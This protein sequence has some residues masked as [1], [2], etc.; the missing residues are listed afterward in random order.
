MALRS[1][2]VVCVLAACIVG[3]GCG[4]GGVGSPPGSPVAGG[5]PTAGETV[6]LGTLQVGVASAAGFKTLTLRSPDNSYIAFTVLYGSRILRLQEMGYERI[7]FASDRDGDYEI[8]TMNAD[9]SDRVKLTRNSAN[10]NDPAWSPDG[11][12][13]AFASDRDGDYEIFAMN[14]DGSSP[15]KLTRNTKDD[16][17]PAWSPDG[18]KI[19]FSGIESPDWE[20]FVMNANGTGR[21][22]LT[23]N[24][25]EDQHPTWS[26]DGKRIAFAHFLSG[27]LEIFV[28]D[29][30]GSDQ[31]NISGETSKD[32]QPSWCWESDKIAY[33]TDRDGGPLQ[34]YTMW[35]D[36]SSKSRRTNAPQ[37]QGNPSWSPQ[38][39][40]DRFVFDGD[41]GG[42]RD[43]FVTSP[44]GGSPVNVT[45]T[46]S[47]HD[48]DPEW[49]PTP[50]ARR[51]LI[52]SAGSDGGSDPPFGAERPLAVVALRRHGLVSA[53]TIGLPDAQWGN[54]RVAAINNI[55]M[56]LVGMKVTAGR[57]NQVVEDNGRGRLPR[58][59]DVTGPPKTGAVLVFFF[60]HS[61][62]IT[63]VI[64]S[65]DSALGAA[66][67]TDETTAEC[68]SGK[69]VLTGSFVAAYDARDSGHNLV[70]GEAH[71]VVL[72][73]RSG[74]VLSTD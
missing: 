9:G 8:F 56:E 4:S 62:R 22:N 45:Q 10:D 46:P 72:D 25:T 16:R 15:V 60:V 41:V 73:A 33:A 59:W 70:Q 53:A 24:G 13:I 69:A 7:A 51:T 1:I 30:D 47:A 14:A 66:G 20:I 21:T 19:A 17:H 34:I 11:K 74:E 64:A 35:P 40:T 6:S 57:I 42:K 31:L 39:D 23:V 2:V 68:V 71:E 55:G 12:K 49:R 3:A 18:K 50:S 61:G 27:Q 38:P 63:S 32:D 52:G 29:A 37:V 36:G 54:V 67:F 5:S 43:I 65:G 44:L 28:M 58:V 26:P 48:E